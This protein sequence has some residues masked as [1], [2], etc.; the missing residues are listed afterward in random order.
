MIHAFGH[1]VEIT[2]AEQCT[3]S[4]VNHKTLMHE[5]RVDRQKRGFNVDESYVLCTR[6]RKAISL[7]I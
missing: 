2:E 3:M 4:S 5:A 1:N 7:K 6:C